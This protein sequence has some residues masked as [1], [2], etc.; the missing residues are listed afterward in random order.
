MSNHILL[1]VPDLVLG[2]GG[3]LLLL[4]LMLLRD[5]Q[6]GSQHFAQTP[7]PFPSCLLKDPNLCLFTSWPLIQGR[8]A[9]NTIFFSSFMALDVF[10]EGGPGSRCQGSRCLLLNVRFRGHHHSPAE[11]MS[12]VWMICFWEE[13]RFPEFPPSGDL[14]LVDFESL[15][16]KSR[17]WRFLRHHFTQ[18]PH[19][20]EEDI[21]AQ[22]RR[23]SCSG[24]CSWGQRRTR[25]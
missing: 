14:G 25:S 13:L 24:P 12:Q 10:P 7:P 17:A 15:N 3:W 20:T 2:T 19:F 4:V 6:P 5:K 1:W 18:L 23:M 21:E 9:W 8:P 16:L 22:R 11:A